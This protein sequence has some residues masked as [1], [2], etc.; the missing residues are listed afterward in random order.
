M[1]VSEVVSKLSHECCLALGDFDHFQ[2]VQAYIQM[3]LCVGLEHF[4]K[5]MEEIVVLTHDGVEIGRYKSEMEA[6]DKLGVHR[7]SI[8]AVANGRRYSAGGYR[9]MK[10]R[11]FDLIP[12]EPPPPPRLF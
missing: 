9:F 4:K 6:S 10:A 5:E 7:E 8:L 2:T 3:A 1:L 11:D 12:R